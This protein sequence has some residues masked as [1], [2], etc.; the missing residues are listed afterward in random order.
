MVAHAVSSGLC[1][2][3]Q[4]GDLDFRQKVLRPFVPVSR[5][6]G[7]GTFDIW[8]LGRSP[9]HLANPL[10]FLSPA[11]ATLNEMHLLSKV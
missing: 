6:S 4:R 10:M 5:S 8:P 1:S 7:G 3:E 2:V 9:S 11:Q